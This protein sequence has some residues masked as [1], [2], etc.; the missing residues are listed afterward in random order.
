MSRVRIRAR[1]K[2]RFI[3]SVRSRVR[4]RSGVELCLQKLGLS[5][6]WF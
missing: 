2:F 3:F 4:F 5:L 1:V 6:G